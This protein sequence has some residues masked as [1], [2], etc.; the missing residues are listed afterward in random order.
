M[1][2]RPQ[3]IAN[4]LC[5]ASCTL[6]LATP[7][8]GSQP[9]ESSLKI[10]QNIKD[11]AGHV[12]DRNNV[13]LIGVTVYEKG[14]KNGMITDV[15]G[16]FQ[17]KLKGSNPT[18][19]FSYVGYKTLEFPADQVP[20][21]V[22][23]EEDVQVMDEVVVVGYAVQKKKDL[24]GST[25]SI[26]GQRCQSD[27]SLQLGPIDARQPERCKHHECFGYAGRRCPRQHPWCGFH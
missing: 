13:P 26:K 25:S 19:V 8:L 21:E 18:I 10:E 23:M 16:A 22:I 17:L 20:M 27:R 14:T 9:I 24:T 7:V 4:W 11:I 12:T 5:I 1:K 6:C 3:R 15:D 2:K